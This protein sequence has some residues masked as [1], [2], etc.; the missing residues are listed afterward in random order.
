MKLLARLFW[1]LPE[2]FHTILGNLTGGWRVVRRR[3]DQL[4]TIAK[5]RWERW[6][7]SPEYPAGRQP[8]EWANKPWS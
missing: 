6:P 1:L 7:Y 8:A 5:Y 4:L 2:P 3:D